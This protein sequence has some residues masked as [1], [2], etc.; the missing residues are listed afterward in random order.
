MRLNPD[1]IRDLLLCVEDLTDSSRNFSFPTDIQ[2]CRR[3]DRYD[4]DVIDYHFEQC[5][6]SG[7]FVILCETITGLTVVK[8]L[9]PSGHRFVDSVR[10]EKI[11]RHLRT[12]IS[13]NG[14]SDISTAL[15]PKLAEIILQRILP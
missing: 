4:R 14:L 6:L 3:L 8:S 11:W 10:S 2:Y 7:Y 13:D 12:Y 1:C 15:L 5:R 9:S